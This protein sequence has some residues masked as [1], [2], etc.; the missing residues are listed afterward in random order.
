MR[1]APRVWYLL[2]SCLR[3]WMENPRLHPPRTAEVIAAVQR[4]AAE[5]KAGTC[6]VQTTNNT[7]PER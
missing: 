5:V 3:P 2:L 1:D 6:A 4:Q 7:D